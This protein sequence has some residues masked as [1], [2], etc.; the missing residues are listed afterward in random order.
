[1]KNV[2][3]RSLSGII[4]IALIV[5]AALAGGWWWYALTALFAVVGTLEYQRMIAVKQRSQLPVLSSAIDLTSTLIVWGVAP[6]MEYRSDSLP[7]VGII[8]LLCLLLRMSLAL[9]QKRG[10]AFAS[11]AA[12]VFGVAY[13]GVPLSLLNIAM[14]ISPAATTGILGMFVLIWLNDTGAFCVGS[15]FGKRRLCERLSPKKSWEGFWG[16]LLFCVAACAIYAAVTDLPVVTCMAYGVVVSV[17]ATWGDLFESMLKRAAGVKDSGNIIP[18]HGGILD[19]ID[20]LL[21]VAPASALFYIL[22]AYPF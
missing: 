6:L 18:G 16:G 11:T 20:S 19:R 13:I 2:L 4:Y 1:M 17:F 10:D 14:L 7:A 8:L 9:S 21:F 3:V 15:L 12:S 22:S 5:G